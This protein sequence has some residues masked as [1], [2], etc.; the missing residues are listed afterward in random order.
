MPQVKAFLSVF[1][2]CFALSFA[3]GVLSRMAGV[4]LLNAAAKRQGS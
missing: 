1:V 4:A 3:V 2:T